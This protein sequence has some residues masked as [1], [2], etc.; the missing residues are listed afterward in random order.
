MSTEKA[1]PQAQASQVLP[2]LPV[3]GIAQIALVVKDLDQTVKNWRELAIMVVAA[4]VIDAIV[5]TQADWLLYPITIL[6]IVGPLLLLGFMGAV[7]VLTTRNLVNNIDRWRQLS[8]PLMS[9]IA[10]GLVLI[11]IMD[12]FRAAVTGG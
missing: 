10:L 3:K 5:L 6:S 9:G 12:V 7:I 4:F 1:N 2:S 8:L 11:T